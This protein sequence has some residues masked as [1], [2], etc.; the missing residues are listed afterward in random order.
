MTSEL[1]GPITSGEFTFLKTNLGDL[2]WRPLKNQQNIISSK[3]VS[4]EVIESIKDKINTLG[5]Q[6][7]NSGEEHYIAIYRDA[8]M[9][10]ESRLLVQRRSS[11]AELLETLDLEPLPMEE[12]LY[13]QF[14]PF[15]NLKKV[16]SFLSTTKLALLVALKKQTGLEWQEEGD[17]IVSQKIT[18]KNSLTDPVVKTCAPNYDLTI[19]QEGLSFS[20]VL[21]PKKE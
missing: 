20:Y 21:S 13:H 7:I 14:N 2:D 18:K 3:A 4:A 12:N 17:N 1:K 19:K 10:K 16:A 6:I 5:A 9:N 15:K 8:L 11:S